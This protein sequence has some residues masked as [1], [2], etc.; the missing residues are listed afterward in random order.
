MSGCLLVIFFLSAFLLVEL[1]V[2]LAMGGCLLV[3]FVLS[4][5]LLV[6]LEV[7]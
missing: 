5:F 1:K 4:A 2:V 3:I 6:D 7:V